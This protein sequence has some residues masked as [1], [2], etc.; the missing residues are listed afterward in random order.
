MPGFYIYIPSPKKKK[1]K[2][3]IYYLIFGLYQ[4]LTP[5]KFVQSRYLTKNKLKKI[6]EKYVCTT[7]G[8]FFSFFFEKQKH[9]IKKKKW[10]S[11]I[12]FQH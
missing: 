4:L 10:S 12:K 5:K 9:I 1:N 8:F 3:Y 7:L 11:N 6:V 2:I